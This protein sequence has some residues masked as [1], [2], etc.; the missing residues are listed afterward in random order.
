MLTGDV[1][2]TIET[3][4]A[5]GLEDSIELGTAVWL[6]SELGG[7]LDVRGVADGD[8]FDATL[9]AISP[10]LSPVSKTP[11]RLAAIVTAMIVAPT[12]AV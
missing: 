2:D 6:A 4:P 9:S 12:I 11:A 5:P 7:A 1:N 10:A 8:T 3:P